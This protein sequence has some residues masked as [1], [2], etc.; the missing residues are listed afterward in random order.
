MDTQSGNQSAA[1]PTLCRAGCGF[2]GSPATE[3]LCSKCFKDALK[4]K[5]DPN[6]Q[7]V[8]SGATLF[9]AASSS[10]ANDS[11]TSEPIASTPQSSTPKM[12]DDAPAAVAEITIAAAT[13]TTEKE[14]HGDTVARPLL[15]VPTPVTA[16]GASTSSQSL[17]ADGTTVVASV[18]SDPKM[19]ASASAPVISDKPL[20]RTRCEKCNKKVGF[21]GFEC[22]CG[23]MFCG[24]HRYSDMHSCSYD[25]KRSGAEEIKKNN[26]VIAKDK[27]QKL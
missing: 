14:K 26:P 17:I 20:E 4:R 18:M 25:Y 5:Q 21:T 10:I 3:N 2:Y 9:T 1:M 19:A 23:G 16:S 24:V 8:S 11:R 12:D 15:N 6:R 22:R 27:I 7:A 13:T